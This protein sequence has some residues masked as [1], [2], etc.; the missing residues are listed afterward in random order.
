M[1]ALARILVAVV[2][3]KRRAR[4]S[5]AV[6]RIQGAFCRIAIGARTST[7]DFAAKSRLFDSDRR[8]LLFAET[9]TV[10]VIKL[11]RSFLV[12]GRAFQ[13]YAV[14]AGREPEAHGA[15]RF[16]VKFGDKFTLFVAN[17]QVTVYILVQFQACARAAQIRHHHIPGARQIHVAAG[18]LGATH[19]GFG[20][21]ESFIEGKL[22]SFR[23][24]HL[25]ITACIARAAKAAHQRMRKERTL[26][27]VAFLARFI[28]SAAGDKGVAFHVA[29]LVD[30]ERRHSDTALRASDSTRAASID[31]GNFHVGIQGIHT[32]AEFFP[33]INFFAEA[34]SLFVG[35]AT[36]VHQHFFAGI[37]A[38]TFRRF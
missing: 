30:H 19:G 15:T 12:F 31:H 17:E 21:L 4:N 25:A 1:H 9:R 33:T 38:S 16:L 3:T 13:A 26:E 23:K 18:V 29:A 2:K 36:I 14:L 27:F 7:L 20:L 10:V 22:I 8:E 37:R 11:N 28:L 6:K 32:L 34:K 35:V 5:V 24:R